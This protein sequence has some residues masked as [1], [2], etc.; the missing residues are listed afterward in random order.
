[1]WWAHVLLSTEHGPS[2]SYMALAFT[3]SLTFL[4]FLWLTKIPH[5]TKSSWPQLHTGE[6]R[7][8]RQWTSVLGN[9]KDTVPSL[10]DLS[11]AVPVFQHVVST[12][13]KYC[14][15]IINGWDSRRASPKMQIKSLFPIVRIKYSKTVQLWH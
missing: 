15:L 8:S 6:G 7:W 2:I 13:V 14:K 3:F 4:T 5:S 12:S 11:W 9:V 1:M 10:S